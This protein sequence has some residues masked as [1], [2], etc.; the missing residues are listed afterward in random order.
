MIGMACDRVWE[1]RIME[2]WAAYGTGS[3]GDN[4]V[5]RNRMRGKEATRRWGSE[6]DK[7]AKG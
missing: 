4:W 3:C 2:K 1:G 7:A 6:R 5:R